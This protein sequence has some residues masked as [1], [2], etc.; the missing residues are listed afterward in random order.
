MTKLPE[1]QKASIGLV[2]F[3][4]NLL[5]VLSFTPFFEAIEMLVFEV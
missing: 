3:V 4:M 2:F 1:S 5:Q